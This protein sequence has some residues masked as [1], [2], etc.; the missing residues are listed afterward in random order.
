MNAKLKNALLS[1]GLLAMFVAGNPV[2]AETV[3][4]YKLQEASV[5][6]LWEDSESPALQEL[7][8]KAKFSN[9]LMKRSVDVIKKKIK[10][11]VPLDQQEN[12]FTSVLKG[13]F[14]NVEQAFED[15][16]KLPTQDVLT[17]SF[18]G[19]FQMHL[20]L[21][22]SSVTEWSS[23]FK[24]AKDSPYFNVEKTMQNKSV[25]T[26]QTLLNNVC[27][28]PI[29][30]INL[31]KANTQCAIKASTQDVVNEIE[32]LNDGLLVGEY[33]GV[34][35]VVMHDPTLAMNFAAVYMLKT[36]NGESPVILFS[37]DF[38][39]NIKDSPETMAFVLAHELGHI[40][41]NHT[42]NNDDSNFDNELEADSF[43][44][45]TL[46]HK[47]Y[48]TEG[49]NKILPAFEK[50]AYSVGSMYIN[51][52]FKKMMNARKENILRHTE[53]TTVYPSFGL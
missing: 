50:A 16:K 31:K 10:L 38:M 45:E 3:S 12:V 32:N 33:D 13:S 14:D 23:S 15:L 42:F 5:S 36:K 17:Q 44:L 6:T 49:L 37:L 26:L 30:S 51:D 48:S 4:A 39:D 1:V 43:A 52:N 27:A 35:V 21:N 7:A 41:H 47:H 24:T 18:R 28:K 8:T 46:K 2:H 11:H 53:P 9:E 40:H 22:S 19:Q 29:Q 25:K 20:A 34:P